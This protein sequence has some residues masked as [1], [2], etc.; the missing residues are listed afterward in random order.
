MN[1]DELGVKEVVLS[2]SQNTL[3]FP[4]RVLPEPYIDQELLDSPTNSRK[5]FVVY[6]LRL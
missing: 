3:K 5:I 1:L 4:F 6:A 2:E